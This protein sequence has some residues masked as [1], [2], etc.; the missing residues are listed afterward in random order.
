M[1]ALHYYVYLIINC[2]K[3]GHLISH[4]KYKTPIIN[5]L[6]LFPK[7]KTSKK[8]MLSK[9]IL[10]QQKN[11]LGRNAVLFAPLAKAKG[12]SAAK[13]TFFLLI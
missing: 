13:S 12:L 6:H 7:Y 8:E 2:I 9:K 11:L 1:P 5:T 10:A 3:H 4:Q